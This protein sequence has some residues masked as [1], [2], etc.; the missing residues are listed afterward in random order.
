M[1]PRVKFGHSTSGSRGRKKNTCCWVTSSGGSSTSAPS[2]GPSQAPSTGNLANA[3]AAAAARA[4]IRSAVFVPENLESQ[5]IITTA[6]YGGTPATGKRSE[7]RRG[8]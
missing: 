5:K 3:V 1:S 8:G 2:S 7:E 4:G 6:V